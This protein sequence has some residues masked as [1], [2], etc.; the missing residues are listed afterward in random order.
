MARTPPRLPSA[1]DRAPWQLQGCMAVRLRAHGAW[2]ARNP[3]SQNLG[4]RTTTEM[5]M[6]APDQAGHRLGTS[7]V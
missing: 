3:R 4:V 2:W 5:G 6:A 7:A 1:L